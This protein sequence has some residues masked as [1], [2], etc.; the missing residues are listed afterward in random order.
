M[1]RIPPHLIT[2]VGCPVVKMSVQDRDKVEDLYG[3]LNINASNHAGIES[4]TV[5]IAEIS[6]VFSLVFASNE[7]SPFILYMDK[8]VGTICLEKFLP[9][10][11]CRKNI[12]ERMLNV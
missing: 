3:W 8:S 6:D 9:T 1:F 11:L 2:F 5:K 10:C 4:S 7:I 12:R